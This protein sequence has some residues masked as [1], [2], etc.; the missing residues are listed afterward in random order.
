MSAPRYA[1]L[2]GKLLAAGERASAPPPAPDDRARAIAAVRRAIEQRARARRRAV[3]VASVAAAAAAVAVAGGVAHHVVRS[4]AMA[5]SAAPAPTAI[6]ARPGGVRII[7]HAVTGSAS[8][9]AAGGV[10]P[11][12]EGRSLAAG[13][14]VVTG[15]EGRVLLA[16][17]TGTSALL[18]QDAEVAIDALGASEQLRLDAGS[19][20]LHVAKL[21]PGERFLVRTPD[22]EVEVRG[23]RFRVSIAAADASCGGGTVTRVA[24]FEGVV[25][26]RRAGTEA[27]VGA[28]EP[29]PAGCTVASQGAEAPAGATP[30]P[31]ARTAPAASAVSTLSEQN[32]LFAQAMAAKRRGDPAAALAGFDRLLARY[33]RSPL[34]ENAAVER[35][36]LLRG[37]DPLRA[38]QAARAYL[39][40]YPNGF[41]RVEAEAVAAE[42]P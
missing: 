25:V 24:V 16:F 9:V 39:A 18:E 34:A 23:T 41:A 42:S 35:M 33:P 32:D 6:V 13:D 4:R 7:G 38:A 36:R 17:S 31:V 22:A 8:V 28:G 5:S 21:A 19:I 40:A 15:H 20:E 14:H 12:A 27:R 30:T 29:W 2:A 3:W 10:L 26:V 37:S 1:R 11:L